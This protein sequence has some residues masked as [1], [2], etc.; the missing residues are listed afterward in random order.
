[1]NFNKVNIDIT[2]T[3]G[4]SFLLISFIMDAG[5]SCFCLLKIFYR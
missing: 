1:M 3:S 5:V 2:V 4:D